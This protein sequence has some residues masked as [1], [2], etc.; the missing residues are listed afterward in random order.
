[1]NISDLET[2]QPTTLTID[3]SA[4]TIGTSAFVS[5]AAAQDR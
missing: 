2:L 4:T 3:K 1:M 5:A